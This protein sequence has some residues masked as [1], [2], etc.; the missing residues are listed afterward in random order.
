MKEISETKDR[1][2]TETGKKGVFT[3]VYLLVWFAILIFL[4]WKARFGA[5]S[6]DESLYLSI[7]YRLQQGDA[8]IWDEWNLSQQSSL[9]TIPFVF[10][11]TH[12]SGGTEGMALAYRYWSVIIWGLVALAVYFRLKD[13]LGRAGDNGVGAAVSSFAFMLY[14]PFGIMT[15]SYNTYALAVLVLSGLVLL[16]VADSDGEGSRHFRWMLAGFLYAYAV[17]CCPHVLM[18]WALGL[19]YTIVK[20]KFRCFVDFTLGAACLALI[21]GIYILAGASIGQVAEAL[22]VMFNDPHHQQVSFLWYMKDYVLQVLFGI[23]NGFWVYI[24]FAILIVIILA[25]KRRKERRLIYFTIG[26]MF[27]LALL[28]AAWIFRRYIN[29]FIFPVN[30]LAFLCLII[31]RDEKTKSLFMCLWLPGMLY[32]FCINMSSNQYWLAI[33]SASC[34]SLIGSIA[35]ISMFVG[36]QAANA[37]EESAGPYGM[38]ILPWIAVILALIIPLAYLRYSF[39]FINSTISAQTELI[40]RGPQKGIMASADDKEVYDTIFEDIETVKSYKPERILL[41]ARDSWPYMTQ[42]VRNA[43]YSPWLQNDIDDYAVDMLVRYYDMDDSR[44]PDVIYIDKD[45]KVFAARLLEE[46][47]YEVIKT[48]PSG[49]MIARPR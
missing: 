36:S 41:F 40:T 28:A 44:K 42:G 39:V 14:A 46:L 24:C 45:Y 33:S 17:L 48:G 47:D 31:D 12:I 10:L 3:I 1:M 26:C 29:C 6:Y 9:A 19:I 34:L 35:I 38:R 43:S 4:M 49:N 8:M 32:T 22:P 37:G 30:I 5:A 2:N 23:P 25:D 7:P 11:Y 21:L 27:T 20:K 16:S 18:V 15:M 13:H